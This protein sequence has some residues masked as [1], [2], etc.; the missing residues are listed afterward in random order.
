MANPDEILRQDA[1]PPDGAARRQPPTIDMEAVEVAPDGTPIAPAA[2]Y[3]SGRP[4]WMAAA[5]LGVVMVV[6]AGAYWSMLPPA[7]PDT[8]QQDAGREAARLEDIAGRLARLESAL[9][10]M[11]EAAPAA[12]VQS[13]PDPAVVNRIAA[14]ERALAPLADR[15]AELER[16]VGENTTRS[17]GASERVDAVAGVVDEMKRSGVDQ[18]S[19]AQSERSTLEGFGDRL[20][21]LEGL[22]AALKSKQQEFDVAARAPPLPAPDKTVRVAVIAAALRTAVERD[23]PFA[24][25]FAAA[26]ALGLDDKALAP[27]EPYAATGVPTQNQLFRELSA[28]VP[29]LLRA[30]APAGHDGGYLD[31]LQASATRMMNI[32]PVGEAPGDDPAT[33][34]GRIEM[35]MVRQDVAGA[36]AELDKLPAPAREIAQAWREKALA[37]QAAVDSA[38]RLAAASFARVAEPTAP[39]PSPR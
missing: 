4:A 9:Q 22:E 26:R 10:S 15:I 39:E 17:R 20:K 35:K 23:I 5:A 6:A 37:R 19:L 14:L 13:V 25:E 38:R 18:K 11:R 29:E 31:R 16:R 36:V 32:R 7:Q 28:L 24:A 33:V 3:A 27:L 8:P 2:R 21:A 1:S 34:I 30:A 12:P